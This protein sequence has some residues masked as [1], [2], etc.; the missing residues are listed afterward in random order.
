MSLPPAAS[1]TVVNTGSVCRTDS[2]PRVLGGS[3]TLDRI[4]SA[5]SIPAAV[6]L[7]AEE[8][9][10]APAVVDGA[11]TLSFVEVAD[12][13]VEV[14]GALVASGVEPGDRVA[15]WAPNSATWITAALGVLA[16]G[17]WLVP[18][19]TRFKGAETAFVL[20]KVDASH[21]FVCDGFLGGHQLDEL[22]AE[23]PGLRALQDPIVMPMPG[24]TDRPEWRAFLDRGDDATRA[25]A[26][27]R[28]AAIGPDDISDVI[29]TS[30]TTGM[31]KGVMLRHGASLGLYYVYGSRLSL[32]RGDRGLVALPFFHT[33]G[34]K[35]GWMALLLNGATTYPVAVFDGITLMESID[36]NEIT[37][38]PGTP[39]MFWPLVDD[40][41]RDEFDLSSLKKA[42]VAATFLPVELVHR[43]KA[44]VGIEIVT[45][46]YGLTEAHSL[47][48]KCLPGDTPETVA[49]T[50]GQ[51]LDGVEV[52]VVDDDDHE[53]ALGEEGEILVRGIGL[54]TGYYGDPAATEAA[55]L[56]GW[57]RTGDIGSIDEHRYMK[58]T[59]R[60]KDIYI[61][62]GFN[63]APSEVENTVIGCDGV[64][65]V[66]VVGVPDHR[67]GEV[68]AAFVVPLAGATLAG[69]DI[70]EFARARIANYKVPRYVWIVDA[71]PVNATGKV[72]KDELRSRHRELE[73]ERGSR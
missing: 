1:V 7:S 53:V 65:Q 68:G 29:F 66:A 6:Q 62:G 14:A 28:I 23:A 17:A 16:S 63:V 5:P 32:Q 11:C 13:M 26:R 69:D 12:G 52:K 2:S 22:R 60:K 30:G 39:T 47:V 24:D 44:E 10:D 55:Y 71:L 59:D 9:G 54:M 72:M 56:D 70:A 21:L 34:Y 35:A 3:S 57:L 38:L 25:E 20:D 36:R 43:L 61:T 45:T 42:I 37:F 8:F 15:V 49:T 31:P 40:P 50:V 67:L 4:W 51:V 48:A 33:F 27:A 58:I 19:N 41:R 64:G 18:V 73:K 46:G